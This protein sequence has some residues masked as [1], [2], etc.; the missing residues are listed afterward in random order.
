SALQSEAEQNIESTVSAPQAS[1]EADSSGEIEDTEA[2]LDEEFLE[3]I[4]KEHAAG[5][6]GNILAM[7]LTLRNK[8]NDRYVTR[9]DELTK[10]DKWSIEYTMTEI[11]SPSRAWSL[12]RACQARRKKALDDSIREEGNVARNYYIEKMRELSQKGREW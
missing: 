3:D 12:Y 8:V 2:S 1:D 9:P 4:S 10:S 11:E 7:T 6:A 5:E